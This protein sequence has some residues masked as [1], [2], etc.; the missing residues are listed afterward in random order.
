MNVGILNE[1]RHI[2]L[3][4]PSP[5]VISTIPNC[6]LDRREISCRETKAVR[7]IRSVMLLFIAESIFQITRPMEDTDNL[8]AI[9]DGLIINDVSTDRKAPDILP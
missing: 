1:R 3:F 6:H 8:Y 7:P 2:V 4:R 5:T 9:L